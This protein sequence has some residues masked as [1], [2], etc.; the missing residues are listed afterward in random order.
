[1]LQS[2]GLEEQFWHKKTSSFSKGMRQRTGLA[3]ALL[4]Q[5]ELLVL[6]EPTDGIDPL[7]RAELREVIRAAARRGATVFLNSHLL[8]ETEK[9]ADHVAILSRGRVIL[10]GALEILRADDRFLVRFSEHVDSAEVAHA[11]GFVP[12][13]AARSPGPA[14]FI[15]ANSNGDELSDALQR[16]L[17]AG[18]KVREVRPLTKDLESLMAEAVSASHRDDGDRVTTGPG[19]VQ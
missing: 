11:H 5:P 7:G 15:Y 19:Q 10:T 2:V 14:T 8:A 6:D 16:C 13:D 17:A 1:M 3:A 9:I 12:A 18:L 4:G